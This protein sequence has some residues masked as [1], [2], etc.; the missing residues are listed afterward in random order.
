MSERRS[1]IVRTC[2]RGGGGAAGEGCVGLA[3]A[4]RGL[5]GIV[6]TWAWWR[7]AASVC[8][9]TSSEV[10]FTPTKTSQR[11]QRTLASAYLS[12]EEGASLRNLRRIARPR[13]ARRIAN[14]APK[15]RGAHVYV[16]AL[17]RECSS[18]ST[19]SACRTQSVYSLSSSERSATCSASGSTSCGRQSQPPARGT[20]SVSRREGA[21]G[22]DA[23]E[24]RAR[25]RGGG[26]GRRRGRR[27]RRAPQAA[28][29]TTR[30]VC[31]CASWKPTCAP[32]GD[33][34][35]RRA[36]LAPRPSRWKRR[37][38]RASSS[39]ISA[40]RSVGVGERARLASSS[41]SSVESTVWSGGG[42]E[43]G[44]SKRAVG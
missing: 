41:S 30:C 17:V 29:Q 3:R 35:P 42:A 33:R 19:T 24:A 16:P 44:D 36:A 11:R 21:E 28:Q 38:R 7:C 5:E 22:R 39:A 15:S 43:E 4:A 2:G 23:V 12:G 6:R 40:W 26:G 25:R 8:A 1:C 37:A 27:P 18:R 32:G 20:R 14:C 9:C 13:I 10:T 31:R 34:G